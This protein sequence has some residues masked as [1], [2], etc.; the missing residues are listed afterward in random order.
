MEVNKKKSGFSF[1]I[2]DALIVLMVLIIAAAGVFVYIKISS[3]KIIT[4]TQTIECTF[5][6]DN[7]RSE[8]KNLV[9]EGDKVYNVNNQVFGVVTGVS[10]TNAVSNVVASDASD[11]NS[12]QVKKYIYPDSDYCKAVLTVKCDNADFSSGKCTV[13]GTYVGVGENISLRTKNFVSSAR[14]S[15]YTVAQDP[16]SDTAVE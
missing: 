7:M 11:V 3:N 9:R 2:V 6:I 12:G 1:N 10:Y 8:F 15:G 5:T 14:C 16:S 4:D 13:G